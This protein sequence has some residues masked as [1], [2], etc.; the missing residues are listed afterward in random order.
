MKLLLPKPLRAW[1]DVALSFV[2]PEICQ[3]C[4]VARASHARSYVCDE[5]REGV[6]WIEAPFCVRC[7]LPFDGAITIDFVCSHCQDLNLKFCWARS[8]VKAQGTVLDAIHKYKYNRRMWFEG[9]LSELL[10]A[11]AADSLKAESWDA[12][13]PIPLFPV[14]EREREFN[15]AERLAR[16]LSL[17]TGIPVD[18][19]IIKRV[20]P[21]KTQTRLSREERS[22]NM[23]R[24]FSLHQRTTCAGKQYVLVDDVFTT[25]ATTNACASVLLKGGAARVGVWTVA[26][27]VI[28]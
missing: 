4:G 9:F 3:V 23:R 21:T 28:A 19:K 16:R 14:K 12:L 13:V 7:G 27:A 25:G 18:C 8:A 15:Q 6:N 17:A 10:V 1:A 22:E 2:Y 26:R 11:A 24:A 5:C 20:L